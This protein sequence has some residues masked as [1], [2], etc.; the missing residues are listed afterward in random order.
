VWIMVDLKSL[1]SELRVIGSDLPGV[2][3]KSA[4]GGYPESLDRTM[5]AF[6]NLPGGGVVIL[7][8][9]ESAGFTPVGLKNASDL[10]HGVATRA[11]QAF[12][13]PLAVQVAVESFENG[14]VVVAQVSEIS[15]THKPCR[16]TRDGAAYM[17]FWDGDYR[18]SQLEIDGFIAN[19][20]TP[21]YD[22]QP[23]AGSGR[24][25]L[26]AQL[27]NDFIRNV[28][29]NDR[30]MPRYDDDELLEKLG[31]T[32]TDGE[33]TVA[34]LLALGEYPQQ[35]FPNFCVQA[36]VLPDGGAESAT[37]VRDAARFT[38][39]L[40]AI[41]EAATDW[42]ISHSE[43]RIVDLPGGRVVDDYD[44]PP[45]AVRELVANSLVHRDLADWSWSRAT[46]VRLTSETLR[47]INPGGLYGVPVERLGLIE[48]SSARNGRLLRICQYLSTSDGRAVE[49][50]ATGM[51][52]VFAAT[53]GAGRRPPSF[54]DQGLTFTVALP[55]D[56][57]V[58]NV[59]LSRAEAAVLGV[60]AGPMSL[61]TIATA[62]QISNESARRTAKRLM[63]KGLLRR[64]GGRGIPDTTY[65]RT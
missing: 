20:S 35:H 18:L 31:V 56:R 44:L 50:L 6:G 40:P 63:A 11:R 33:L 42:I 2:E 38:G 59:D 51:P 24:G 47:I 17:R 64:H 28:R 65:E 14:Q 61:D 27:L 22:E 32:R 57:P 36:A 34:G 29:S 15:T 25:D 13:P 16:S 52:K 10:A 39:P 3:V 62:L 7:G 19:R 55:R 23:I 54:F 4:A 43:H 46:E 53:A 8:L 49:A 41:L 5:C 9:N 60:V 45:V 30:R 1:V 21:R 12:D 58:P 37:R 48:V 26:D